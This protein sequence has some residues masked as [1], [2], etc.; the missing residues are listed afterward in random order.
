[1]IV[2]LSTT[3][4]DV[5]QVRDAWVEAQARPEPAPPVDE[6][7][8]PWPYT[9]FG[10]PGGVAERTEMRDPDFT[11]LRFRNG[12]RVNFKRT[13]YLRDRVDL[14]VSFGAGQQE[15][16]P[17]RQIAAAIGVSTFSDAGLGRLGA[18]AM[19]RALQGRIWS[20]TLSID[21]TA[22]SLSG[23][24]RPADLRLELQVLAAY[25]TDPGF[26]PELE[27]GVALLAEATDKSNRIE[28]LRAAQIALGAVLP[29]PHVADPPSREQYAAVRAVDAAAALRPAMTSAL[30][31]VT[32]VGDVDEAAVVDALSRT[33]GA[34]PPRSPTPRARPDAEVARYPP[35]APPIVRATHLGLRDKAAVLVVWPL[36]VWDPARQRETRALTLLRE[37]MA[38]AVR[39]ELRERLGVTYTPS[40][41]LSL[42]RGGDQGTFTVAVQTGPDQAEAVRLGVLAVAARFVRDGVSAAEL[43]AVRKP[44]LEDTAR[45]MEQNGW[46]LTTLDG[47]WAFPY[48][49]QQQRTWLPELR[50]AHRGGGRRRGPTLA[51][52]R[53]RWW[54]SPR[55][56][57]ARPRVRPPCPRRRP[58]RRR[59]HRRPQPRSPPMTRI[60]FIGLGAM[61]GGMAA[62]PGD[63]RPRAVRAFDLSPAA[64]DRA[65]AAGC[66][67]AASAAEALEG[68]E[69]VI[70]ML[71]AGP[72][73]RKV[74][75]EEVLAYAPRDAVLIDCST[76]D[77]G[78][79]PAR[80]PPRWPRAGRTFADAPVSGGTAAADA[81]QLA[82]M[83][84]CAA[85][86]F[87]QREGG[88]GAH[89]QGGDP[90]GRRRRG[91]GGEDLQ[92]H[93]ARHQHAG[94]LRGLRARREELGL[95]PQ[96]FHDIAS[97][98]SGQCW[99]LTTYAP[100]PG[101]GPATASDRGYEGGFLT[102][103]ML[104][105]LKLAQGA[106]AEAGASTP[107]GAQ[108]EAVYAL[109]ANLG[110]GER[111][112]PSR[113]RCCAGASIWRR[114]RTS[115]RAWI[116]SRHL[117]LPGRLV[118]GAV[119]G[120]AAGLALAP[121]RR[122]AGAG[123][124]RAGVA[125]RA[126]PEAQV[127]HTTWVAA[128]AWL[129]MWGGWTLLQPF[130][131]SPGRR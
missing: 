129:L 95:D 28:P 78:S 121:R 126:E 82:F 57:A 33:L 1:M 42:D 130:I 14:R 86:E 99:S 71:P 103:L 128:V 113:C 107:L 63:G 37:V 45:R 50:R 47:S 53:T 115:W 31:E 87:A 122:P 72:H 3:P 111:T 16:T 105:D 118:D 92:Q 119:R 89:G 17:D 123:G 52:R 90:R 106:A 97:V 4:V 64:L 5:A 69:A 7:V 80:S 84:G 18:E 35:Q 94:R 108:A 41:G 51:R 77:V 6:K 15:L 85:A 40:V 22:F 73:V 2:V 11:R 19:G 88:A 56:A 100:W 36:Y 29:L 112:S 55:R 66:R 62:P 49:L 9:D 34:L 46:W 12:L 91:P 74:Y 30:L 20:A 54:P 83:V 70:T 43:E 38:E 125:R 116:R 44:L 24:T 59:S 114:R 75:A 10:P 110:L 102:S 27:R 109:M 61:G 81:G 117:H 39:R 79:A 21:R 101:V 23:A 76:I 32:V 26:R 98:S 96:K 93:G 60:A 120:A 8:E 131:T 67:P 58:R 65:E 124:R 48:K 13:A 25:L 68:A 127:H 104:K